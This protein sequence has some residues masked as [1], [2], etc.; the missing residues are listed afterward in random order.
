MPRNAKPRPATADGVDRRLRVP[1]GGAPARPDVPPAVLDAWIFEPRV[2]RRRRG[3]AR[4]VVILHGLGDSKASMAGLAHILTGRGMRAVA[5]DLRGHGRSTGDRIAYGAFEAGDVVELVEA[6]ATPDVLGGDLAPVGLY[7]T[8][9]GAHVAVQAAA[10]DDRIDRVVAVGTYRSLRREVPH[11]VALRYPE[12]AHLSPERIQGAVDA[13]G[14]RAGFDPD[15]ASAEA[16]VA[17][18]NA[19]VLFIHGSDDEVVPPEHARAL[20]DR[21]GPRCRLHLLEGADH[22]GSMR[23]PPLR[24][25]LLAWLE[26]RYGTL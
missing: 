16:A 23:G 2:P 7:A 17:R 20:V 4:T 18:G 9:Y 15:R 6:L 24:R 21:C 13:A 8:S 26:G 3:A 10:L 19:R 12:R 14:A 5:V 22:L 1:V 11:F 25:A